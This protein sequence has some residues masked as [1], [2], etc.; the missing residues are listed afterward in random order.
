MWVCV[1]LNRTFRVSLVQFNFVFEQL[2][3][4]SKGRRNKK[5]KWQKKKRKETP[6]FS[7]LYRKFR[8]KRSETSRIKK[9]EDI[10][11]ERRKTKLEV[12]R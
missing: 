7:T 10:K 5:K 4:F 9:M 11:D 1:Q 6:R 3:I 2:I 12:K 8:V